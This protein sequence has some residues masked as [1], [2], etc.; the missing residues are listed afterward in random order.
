MIEIEC[1]VAALGGLAQPTFTRDVHK[2]FRMSSALRDEV[3]DIHLNISPSLEPEYFS[4]IP[5]ITNALDLHTVLERL[6]NGS[7]DKPFPPSELGRP[8]KRIGLIYATK[9]EPFPHVLGIM[10]D[11]GFQTDDDVSPKRF[12]DIARQGCAVFLEPQPID[13]FNDHVTFTTI[14]ELGHVF[15]L[16]HAEG[17]ETFMTETK[18]NVLPIKA[19]QIFSNKQ[20]V[21]LSGC[22]KSSNVWPGGDYFRDLT[23][24]FQ[25]RRTREPLRLR[26]A[27]SQ[28]EVYSF[29]PFELDIRLSLSRNAK[30][31]IAVPQA[32]D[33]GYDCFRIWIESPD[34]S[35]RQHHPP[36]H[37]CAQSKSM[38][39]KPGG[40]FERDISLFGQS[41]G[42]TF[43]MPGEYR[44]WSELLLSSKESIR[45]NTVE[46]LVKVPGVQAEKFRLLTNPEHARILFY[47]NASPNSQALFELSEFIKKYP[48]EEFIGNVAY[49]AG[50]AFASSLNKVNTADTKRDQAKI[51][52]NLLARAMDHRGLGNHARKLACNFH[53]DCKQV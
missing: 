3:G 40:V 13:A 4:T 51:A 37:Y 26:V 43:T 48:N 15:N 21:W 53:D 11:R 34:G 5:P 19:H 20:Q 12:H 50:R 16:I 9:Y 8:A 52:C 39:I 30:R 44:I 45:S 28:Q 35:R 31:E 36:N 22:S 2:D 10:F 49:A 33:T 14:H 23:G 1:Q 6:I 46:L 42:Y 7:P 38:Q 47:R 41:G 29:E 18:G 24:I 32:I 25:V 17:A 27:L